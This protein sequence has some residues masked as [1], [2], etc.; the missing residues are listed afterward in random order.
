M[1]KKVVILC[2]IACFI[3]LCSHCSKSITDLTTDEAL[4]LIQK[5][6]DSPIGLK[7]STDSANIQT[8]PVEGVEKENPRY[9]IT[10]NN[11][12]ISLSSEIYQQLEMEIPDFKLPIKAEQLLF[13]YGP[14][15]DY[16]EFSSARNV[17]FFLDIAELIGT[18]EKPIDDIPNMKLAYHFGSMIFKNY[19]ISPLLNSKDKNVIEVLIETLASAQNMESQLKDMRIEFDLPDKGIQADFSIESADARAEAVPELLAAFLKKEV[20]GKSFSE[21]L[22]EGKPLFNLSAEVKNESLSIK[23]LPQDIQAGLESFRLEYYLKPSPDKASFTFG[24][25]LKLGNFHL[26]GLKQKDVEALTGLNEMN[27]EFSL[28]KISPEFLDTYFDVIRSARS[29]TISKDPAQQQEMSMKGMSLMNSFML[30]KPI[31]TLALKPLDHKLGKVEA[32]GKF[33][34]VQ[35]GPPIGKGVITIFDVKAIAEKLKAREGIPDEVIDKIMSK[36]KEVFVIGED[37]KGTL[38]LEVKA[39]DPTKTY[40]NGKEL[41]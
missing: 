8:A 30:S 1:K 20:M 25:N 14:S 7:I 28:E 19:N 13:I 32:E 18:Q 33:Q 3:W 37:G 36:I 11:P 4:I 24:Y 41:F 9:L 34:F 12:D 21:M 38:T 2:F 29:A 15:D 35:M 23:G 22:E 40:L 39:D 27:L 31:M 5:I 17:D 16:C 26:A 10:V 6:N